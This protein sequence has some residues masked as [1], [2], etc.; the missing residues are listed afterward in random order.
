V[1]ERRRAHLPGVDILFG[2]PGPEGAD[3][4]TPSE[5]E[6]GQE[7]GSPSQPRPLRDPGPQPVEVDQEAIA[8]LARVATEAQPFAEGAVGD[9]DETTAQVGTLLS[10]MVTAVAAHHVVEIGSPSPATS[11]WMAGAMTQADVLTTISSNADV[12]SRLTRGLR[13][14][15][16]AAHVR[17]ITG[18]PEEVLPRLS[19]GGYDVLVAHGEA[20]GSRRLRDHAARLLRAG[21]TL[22]LV[23][24]GAGPPE[25]VRAR[26]AL[27]RELVDDPRFRV[28]VLAV[29]GGV[30]LGAIEPDTSR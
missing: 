6:T 1:V 14:A 28:S 4:E 25:Q 29:G 17:T 12:Q 16:V 19:D 5:G 30:A 15:D 27:V 7:E 11:L 23:G 21:G 24:V 9:T 8:G 26:R 13:Q 10:F 22:I 2:S 18:E 20:A 3:A